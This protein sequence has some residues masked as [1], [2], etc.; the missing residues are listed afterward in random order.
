MSRTL[1]RMRGRMRMARRGGILVRLARKMRAV[2]AAH[3]K[4]TTTD[5]FDEHATSRTFRVEG[6]LR[7]RLA[8]GDVAAGCSADPSR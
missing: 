6:G 8:G 4:I 5:L 7:L 2:Y 3:L 1:V